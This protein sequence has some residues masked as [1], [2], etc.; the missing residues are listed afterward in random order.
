MDVLAKP[1][2]STSAQLK[3]ALTSLPLRLPR[4]AVVITT[5]CTLRC[6]HCAHLNSMY[7]DDARRDESAADVTDSVRRVLSVCDVDFIALLGGE[8]MLHPRLPEII[9]ALRDE[10][11]VGKVSITTNGT[12]AAPEPLLQALAHPKTQVSISNY[13][14]RRAPETQALADTLTKRG[15]RV[16]LADGTRPWADAGGVIPRGRAADDLREMYAR[17]IFAACPTI[18]NGKMYVCPRHANAVNLGL[19][20]ADEAGGVDLSLSGSGPEALRESVIDE[21]YAREFVPACDLCDFVTPDGRQ[22]W[23]DRA[24]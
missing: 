12:L 5:R 13:G 6:I 1:R 14:Q 21:I 9:R 20:P 24:T 4:I 18:L 17:C 8:P 10:P 3:D 22:K 7:G 23:I 16:H 15:I 11:R 19:I 2:G